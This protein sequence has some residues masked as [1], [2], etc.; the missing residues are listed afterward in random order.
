VS[1]RG[2]NLSP[3][4]RQRYVLGAA[5][6][7][8]V[9]VFLLAQ[10][11]FPQQYG[12]PSEPLRF[13]APGH[14][15]PLPDFSAFRDTREKK[16]AF[17][18]YIVPVIE[19]RNAA[20]LAD[21]ERVLA[22]EKTLHQRRSLSTAQREQLQA[23]VSD[24]AVEPP[25]QPPAALIDQLLKRVDMVPVSLAVSQSATE[26]AW[27]S[28][29][30]AQKGNNL[31]GEWCFREGCGIVPGKRRTGA[32][33]EVA[34][35]E[36]PQESVDS[37]IRNLNT[38]PSYAEFREMRDRMRAQNKPLNGAALAEGLQD[39]SERGDRYV[40]ELRSMILRNKLQRFDAKPVPAT[41]DMPPTASA[42]KPIDA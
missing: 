37:Y 5:F 15:Q 21:R 16:Q 2:E 25:D 29:R 28:S 22:L 42:P 30:F 36:S 4:I 24:Y 40:H 39:Y 41:K 17:F 33:H 11:L 10:H 26:S 13:E 6:C 19:A 18:E 3:S 27:G 23:L 7:G 1:L 20:V 12:A 32:F 14:E 9:L 8:A 35:F 34:R 31:F 38:H